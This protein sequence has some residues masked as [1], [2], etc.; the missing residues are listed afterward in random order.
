MLKGR[1]K[2]GCPADEPCDGGAAAAFQT[3]GV[4]ER[5]TS[6]A[7]FTMMVVVSRQADPS[8]EGFDVAAAAVITGF[9]GKGFCRVG[10]K[11]AIIIEHGDNPPAVAQQRVTQALL[12]PFRTFA[13]TLAN[14]TRLGFRDEGFGFTES[15]LAR[16]CVEFF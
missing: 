6:G 8:E 12:D 3:E 2:A 5:T 9:K 15:F 11:G 7:A 4:V 16:L 1:T 10:E 13:A 14:Q